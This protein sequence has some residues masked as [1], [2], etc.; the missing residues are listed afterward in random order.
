MR[1]EPNAA[2]SV[3]PEVDGQE[4]EFEAYARVDFGC[5]ARGLLGPPEYSSP[6]DPGGVEWA[7]VV[8]QGETFPD[9]DAFEG[10][11][12]ARGCAFKLDTDANCSK[13]QRDASERAE[14][15][16]DEYVDDERAWLDDDWGTE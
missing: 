5:P 12:L 16:P 6:E 7:H 2:I 4:L 3:Y 13:A 14:P 10:W 8:G 9:A 1:T 11:L 15:D